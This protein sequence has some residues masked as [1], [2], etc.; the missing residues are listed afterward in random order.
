MELKVLLL[1]LAIIF[2]LA[3]VSL[4]IAG[5]VTSEH[6][7]WDISYGLSGAGAFAIVQAI[8][9]WRAPWLCQAISPV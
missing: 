3:A 5:S 9:L 8:L 1:G 6:L 4:I 7:L 2:G